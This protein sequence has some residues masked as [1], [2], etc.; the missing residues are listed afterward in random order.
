VVGNQG[1]PDFLSDSV[2]LANFMPLSLRK[3]AHVAVG[4]CRVVGNQGS[5]GFPVG[6]CGVGELHAAFF[7][8]SRTRGRG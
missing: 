5:P 2:A 4:E 3:A 7:T 6:L 8:E 1:S